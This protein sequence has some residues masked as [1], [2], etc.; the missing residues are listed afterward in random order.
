[1]GIGM[2]MGMGSGRTNKTKNFDCPIAKTHLWKAS[3]TEELLKCEEPT[4]P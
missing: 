1:M 3:E 4:Q 2:E